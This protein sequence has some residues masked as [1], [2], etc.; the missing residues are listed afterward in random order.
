VDTDGFISTVAGNGLTGYSS[1]G[2]A[3]TN[4]SL[5]NPAGVALDTSGNLF[6]ADSDNNR[7]RKVV[8][9][10]APALILNNI[11][12]AN[13]G[14]YQVII[15]SPYGS[16]TSAV[17][18]VTVAVPQ[19]MGVLHP[20]S[21]V[22]LTFSGTPGATYVFQVAASLT[23][24]NNWQPV[25]TNVADASGNVSFSDTNTLNPIRFYRLKL[26]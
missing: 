8:L 15:T 17:A 2:G 26:P 21:G 18:R 6:I 16:V 5:Y 9:D 4:S 20:G 13:G 14:N 25:F 3:A 23:A 22:L 12:S 1:D 19:L 7:I 24:S 11:A 10:A